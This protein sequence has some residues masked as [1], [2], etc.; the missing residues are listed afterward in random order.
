MTHFEP[1]SL[2]KIGTNFTKVC[3]L[4]LSLL[5]ASCQGSSSVTG[6]S[7]KQE[8]QKADQ[9]VPKAAK[10][11][12]PPVDQSEEEED[13]APD[14]TVRKGVEGDPAAAVP[15]PPPRLPPSKLNWDGAKMIGTDQLFLIPIE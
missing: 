15:P 10:P 13:T 9:T 2:G 6:N 4:L 8:G 14:D 11:K 1:Q 12:S 7:R 5:L 3:T